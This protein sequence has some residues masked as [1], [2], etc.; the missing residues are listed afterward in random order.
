MIMYHLTFDR[1]NVC[2]VPCVDD[3]L[4]PCQPELELTFLSTVKCRGVAAFLSYNT[5]S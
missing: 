4:F 1:K 5:F 2:W 3:N